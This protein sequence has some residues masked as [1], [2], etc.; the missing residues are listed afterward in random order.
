MKNLFE[1]SSVDE[2]IG[3]LETLTPESKAQWGKMNVAQ[4]L[5]HCIAPM[6]MAVGDQ[7]PKRL[8]IGRLLGPIFKS[9]WLNEQP[10]QKNAPTDPTFV[11]SGEHELDIERERLEG[12]IRRF[13]AGGAEACT[14]TPHSFFGP[15][16]PDEWARLQY[17]HL[18][19][20]LQQFGA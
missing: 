10:L 20:H 14:T 16:T 18:D 4:A 15:L 5:A 13:H 9:K 19:H 8:F 11:R 17:K 1:A 3:R 6:E 12:L 2:V 7:R